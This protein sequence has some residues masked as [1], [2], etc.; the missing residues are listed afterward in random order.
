MRWLWCSS[1]RNE[2]PTVPQSQKGI[3]MMI[4]N[5]GGE[6]VDTKS[7]TSL[8]NFS[9][10]LIQDGELSCL[11]FQQ[12]PTAPHKKGNRMRDI[13][14][15]R[16][17]E[18]RDATEKKDEV[19]RKAII[20]KLE[21][22]KKYEPFRE[23]GD[24]FVFTEM[25]LVFKM[26][27][28]SANTGNRIDY[29]MEIIS[30]YDKYPSLGHMRHYNGGFED[31]FIGIG[32]DFL[33]VS[34]GS[35]FRET[36]SFAG[37]EMEHNKGTMDEVIDMAALPPSAFIDETRA[38][39][40]PTEFSGEKGYIITHFP[41]ENDKKIFV[42]VY[43]RAS[44]IPEVFREDY[45]FKSDAPI[46]NADGYWLRLRKDY[47]DFQVVDEL[48]IAVPK[49]RVHKEFASDGWQRRQSVYTLKEMRFNL[50]LPE[51]FFDIQYTDLDDDKG[52]RK[53]VRTRH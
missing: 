31:L 51:H 42:K 35:Q 47:S 30:Q 14:A 38:S 29:R 25:S 4:G 17:Q 24:Y 50:G 15:F 41:D 27:P 39:V 5:V 8:L 1:F 34:R 16:E 7:I 11:Y 33:T 21:G 2:A 20:R 48:N 36:P 19:L 52:K 28:A 46:A 3:L 44:S 45:Y 13:E 53:K 9:K 22:E 23:S 26:R 43:V 40:E 37:I 18:L 12:F 6:S 32:T 49:V 10:T